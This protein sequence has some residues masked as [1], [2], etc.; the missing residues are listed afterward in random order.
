MIKAVFLDFDGTTYSHKTKKI[1]DS[2]CKAI[3]DAQ[4]NGV[5]IMLST[6]R[7]MEELESFDWY[8]SYIS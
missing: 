5:K 7:D 6:G 8:C 1:P 4:A 3:L 2:A